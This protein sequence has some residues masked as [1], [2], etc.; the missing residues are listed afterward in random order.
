MAR[1]TY[2]AIFAEDDG[3]YTVCFP[4][5]DNCI[6]CGCT[7]EAAYEMAA[8]ALALFLYD[9]EQEGADIP[10]PTPLNEVVC[11]GAAHARPVEAD[12]AAYE[13]EHC[14]CRKNHC[15]CKD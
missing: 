14:D 7:L 4:D 3:A 5:F 10:A 1:Y 9:L 12:T 13:Q 2:P 15:G 6:S 11:H 8:D